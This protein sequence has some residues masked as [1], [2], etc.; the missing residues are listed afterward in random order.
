MATPVEA[1]VLE[2]MKR[3]QKFSG[4]ELDR[5]ITEEVGDPMLGAFKALATSML[6]K[7]NND[8]VNQAVHLMVL[9]Y[10]MRGQVER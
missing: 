3:V 7:E 8:R 10:L 4:K 9:A 6:G 1:R 2:A 5:K